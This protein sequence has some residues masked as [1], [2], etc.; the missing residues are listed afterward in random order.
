MDKLGFCMIKILGIPTTLGC[1][2]KGCDLA[3]S[4]LRSGGLTLALKSSNLEYEDLGDI[5]IDN[6]ALSSSSIKNLDQIIETSENVFVEL[7]RSISPGDKVLSVGGD[8]SMA[9]GTIFVSTARFSDLS[10]IWIDA[11]ADCNS[12]QT[13]PTGNVH[14]MPLSTVLGDSLFSKFDHIPV[15]KENVI[16]I[17]IKDVDEAEWEYLKENKIT[18]YTIDDIVEKGMGEIW[19]EID[20]KIGLRPLHVSMDIDGLDYDIAPGTGIVNNGGINYREIKYLVKKISTKNLVAVDIAEINPLND[21]E[22]KTRDLAIELACDY[23]GGKW[24]N[25]E[26]YLH[27]SAVHEVASQ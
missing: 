7:T 15:K 22:N 18:Y 14:G 23:F 4:A 24:T 27:S 5:V 20:H 9:I 25:Y 3:P 8:H 21:I 10:L 26:R 17:G 2:K 12:P 16:L 11:H 6:T 1:N 13:S 19:A